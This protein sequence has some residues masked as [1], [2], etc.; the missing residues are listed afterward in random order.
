M[1][2]PPTVNKKQFLVDFH[3]LP[4]RWTLNNHQIIRSS[5]LRDK[6]CQNMRQNMRHVL[7]WYPPSGFFFRFIASHPIDHEKRINMVAASTQ[8]G[9]VWWHETWTQIWRKSLII[10]W[11]YITGWWLTDPSEKYDFVSW[12]DYSQDTGKIKAMFQTTN[13]IRWWLLLSHYIDDYYPIILMI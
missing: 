11:T 1:L 9:A 6:T 10:C 8:K 3:Q 5:H 13:Q 2:R 12:D 4:K 7:P